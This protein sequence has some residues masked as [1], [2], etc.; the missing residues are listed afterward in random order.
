MSES[1]GINLISRKFRISN[2]NSLMDWIGSFGT[3]DIGVDIGTSNTVLFVKHKGLVF[4]E[5]SVIAR[6]DLTKEYFAFGTK[7]EEMEGKTPSAVRVIRPMKQSAIIDYSGAAYLLNCIVNHSYLK[8]LFFHPRLMM[9]VPTGINGV[10]RRA[11]LE[12]AVA[13]GARKTVLI[14]QPIAAM[15]G[16]G[17]GKQPKEGTMIVDLGGGSTKIAVLSKHGIVAS[18]FSIASGSE[19]DQAVLN[20]V[21]D[22]YHILIGR[23]SAESLKIALGALWD[24]KSGPQIAEISGLSIVSGLPVKMAVTGEDIAH[25]I[26]PV[27]YKIFKDIRDVLQRTPPSLLQAIKE[28]GIILVGGGAQLR[29]ID[30]LISRVIGVPAY[31]AERPSYVN[32]VGAGSALDYINEFRDSL[33][34]LH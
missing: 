2:P 7:A 33:Q 23:K 1:T 32:A 11:L 24:L 17:I 14:D 15:M 25:A 6:N 28:D 13:I 20:T 4:P 34:D 30:K 10:Q 29:G 27:L 9:C 19:M 8:G 22:R 31:V 26:N 3:E 12:A 5:A 18:H 21:R 16:I